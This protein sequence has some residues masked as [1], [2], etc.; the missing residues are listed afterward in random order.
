MKKKKEVL[1]VCMGCGERKPKQELLRIV[2]TPEGAFLIDETG[3]TAGRG[4][5][6][7]KNVACLERAKKTRKVERAFVQMFQPAEYKEME[8]ALTRKLQEL[9]DHLS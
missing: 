1:R 9:T 8:D 6:L 4:A 3:K 7:C 2:R 5:Y